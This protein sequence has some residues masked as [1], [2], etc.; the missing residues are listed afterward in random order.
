[1]K[2]FMPGRIVDGHVGGNTVYSRHIR[3]GLNNHGIEVE[4]IIP[5]KNPYT[6]M[7]KET[8]FG[9]KKPKSPDHIIHYVA[10][11]GPLLKPK[12][13]SVVTVHGVASRWINVSRSKRADF[14]WRTRVQKAIDLSDQVITVSESSANDVSHEFG[15]DKE[16]IT[17]I[18]HGIDTDF[19]QSP[20]EISPENL[21]KVHSPYVLYL[22]NIEP[23]KNL[24]PLLKAFQ[25][26]AV[27]NLGLQLVIAGK[28]AWDF[29]DTMEEIEKTPN[30]VHLGFVSEDDRRALM[31]HAHLFVFPSLYEGFGFP[32]LE[33]LAAGTVVLSS[34]R[35][36]LAEVAGPAIRL[37]D[38][39]V[40]GIENGLI[41]A[42][43]DNSLRDACLQ[44]GRS[45]ASGFTWTKSVES[46]IAV[47]RKVLG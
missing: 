10:D 1:M 38:L 14:V 2:V 32:V 28:P 6:T 5:G 47:Y 3:E 43:T 8:F 18:P 12:Y 31:Q 7:V 19:F 24:V 13:P 17:V 39:T 22:G 46:H 29:T 25:T 35:G 36:S 41:R 33:A 4:S 27:Q 26:Q 40:E 15:I 45:W 42:V 34:S 11:T 16:S 44:E 23:R 9:L 30:T 37:E 21:R 20:C